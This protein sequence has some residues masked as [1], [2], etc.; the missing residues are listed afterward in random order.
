M[1]RERSATLKASAKLTVR[2]STPVSAMP[3]MH[4]QNALAQQPPARRRRGK[5]AGGSV[6]WRTSS[7]SAKKARDRRHQAEHQPQVDA[8]GRPETLPRHQAALRA[9]A[10]AEQRD[11]CAGF[12]AIALS[13]RYT[14]QFSAQPA[15]SELANSSTPVKAA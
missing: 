7:G 13:S 9:R 1:P 5:L 4:H 3:A 10:F 6:T 14:N 11:R 12:Q 15:I 8:G 2:L